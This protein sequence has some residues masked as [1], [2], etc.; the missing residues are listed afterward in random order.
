VAG[1]FTQNRTLE[2]MTGNFYKWKMEKW[3]NEYI[4]TCDTC[5]RMKSPQY[6]K[7]GLAQLLELSYSSWEFTLGDFIM[8]L[9]KLEGHTQIMVIVDNFSKMAH[10]IVLTKTATTRDVTEA[11]LWEVWKLH[12]LP[13][14][15]ISN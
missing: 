3:I 8:A 15:I 4:Q 1:Y 11:F 13:E 9:P 12:E 7:F 5:Q 14:R 6:A 2:L 10:F